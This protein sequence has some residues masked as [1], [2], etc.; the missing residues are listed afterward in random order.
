[1]AYNDDI[2]WS[3]GNSFSSISYS[4][5][6]NTTYYIKFRH[7]YTTQALYARILISET[8]DTWY[9]FEVNGQTVYI[10]EPAV[11]TTT[12]E[13]T[14]G[15]SILNNKYTYSGGIWTKVPNVMGYIPG[16]GSTGVASIDDPNIME[17]ISA[18]GVKEI[19]KNIQDKV[20]Q[21]IDNLI[22]NAGFE[23]SI[24]TA[25]DRSYVIIGA[26]MG[27]IDSLNDKFTIPNTL[28][29]TAY[30]ALVFFLLGTNESAMNANYYYI[31][32]KAQMEYQIF[33]IAAIG[34]SQPPFDQAIANLTS[35]GATVKRESGT[36]DYVLFGITGAGAL[37]S[38]AFKFSDIT[39]PKFLGNGVLSLW[40]VGVALLTITGT[41]YGA[42]TAD[43]PYYISAYPTGNCYKI[44]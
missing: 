23:L 43:V 12:T 3:A 37:P 6:A 31:K 36:G 41:A 2:N 35:F 38:G 34:T 21:V 11:G 33:A 1:M 15:N 26:G 14:V 4:M 9:Q 29:I 44:S 27:A 39:I 10:K 22:T 24:M 42:F 5:S 16:S 28:F 25:Q 7:C 30:K 8:V 13:A 18:S 32:A 19:V 17:Y 40:P 20:N